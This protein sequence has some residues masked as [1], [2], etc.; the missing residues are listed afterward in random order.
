MP[1]G[2]DTPQGDRLQIDVT[3]NLKDSSLD[4]VT[5]IV[6]SLSFLGCIR[7]LHMSPPQHWHGFFQSGTNWADGVDAVTQCPIIPGE[8][9]L[10][11]FTVPDQAVFPLG[12]I[13]KMSPT[14]SLSCSLGD[15]LVSQSLL[16]PIL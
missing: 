15:I 13:C 3:D 12:H 11:N 9:F 7:S 1:F 10:Y 5:S 4:L 6:R 8:S 16:S 2:F 14:G